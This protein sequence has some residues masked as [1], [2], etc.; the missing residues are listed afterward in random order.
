MFVLFNAAQGFAVRRTSVRRS[1]KPAENAEQ[2]KNGHLWM[3]TS[4]VA[5]L[6]GWR[7]V[8]KYCPLIAGYLNK[9]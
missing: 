7:S 8:S 6:L 2:D 5:P 3:D 9:G 4:Y 1:R